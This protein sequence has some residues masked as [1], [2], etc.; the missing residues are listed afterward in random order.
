M[1]DHMGNPISNQDQQQLKVETMSSFK[2][3]KGDFKA[4]QPSRPQV[5]D[6]SIDKSQ[7]IGESTLLQNY[8]TK[9]KFNKIKKKELDKEMYSRLFS[10]NYTQ[11]CM[12]SQRAYSPSFS[13][14]SSKV[15]LS[16]VKT[17]SKANRQDKS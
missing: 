8:G 15:P 14:L 16:P 3:E 17:S 9:T 12:P 7:N 10:E 2:N 6:N 4:L 5:I 11:R 1:V 13:R